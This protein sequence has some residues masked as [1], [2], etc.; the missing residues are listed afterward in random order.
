VDQPAGEREQQVLGLT[1]RVRDHLRELRL[2]PQQ[3]DLPS[4]IVSF[5]VTDPDLVTTRLRDA[6]VRVAA[7]RG[8]V[9]VGLH[10]YND[11]RDVDDLAR[12]LADCGTT[13]VPAG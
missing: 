6:G 13:V 3:T 9:R 11:E 12:A 1:D 5:A 10:V 4:P 2:T 7:R 8:R